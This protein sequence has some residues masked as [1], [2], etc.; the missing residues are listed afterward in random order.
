M[1]VREKE[2]R[3]ATVLSHGVTGGKKRA[4]KRQDPPSQ[5]ELS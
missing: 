1:V 2:S 4:L 5:M 3:D